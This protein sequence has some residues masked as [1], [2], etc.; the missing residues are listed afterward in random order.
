[1]PASDDSSDKLTAPFI[2]VSPHFE[3]DTSSQTI[4]EYSEQRELIRSYSF[5]DKSLP[6]KIYRDRMTGWFFEVAERLLLE[7]QDV[8]A[9]HMV[10]PLIEAIEEHIRGESSK[11]K[12]AEF[13][14]ASVKR[15]FGLTDSD[16]LNLIYGGLRCGFAH[17]GF[18][19]DDDEYYNILLSSGLSRALIY[20]D[21]VLWVDSKKYVSAIRQAFDAFYNELSADPNKMDKFLKLWNKDWQMSLRVPGAGGTAAHLSSRAGPQR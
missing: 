17:H 6:V 3:L 9:V 1:M 14:K 4:T 18:L 11:Y 12:S 2:T 5:D 16:A 8:A 13:F 10:T 15:I 19:K 20:N 21:K 7:H